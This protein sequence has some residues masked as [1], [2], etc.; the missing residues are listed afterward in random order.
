MDHAVI[1]QMVSLARITKGERVLEI[2]TGTGAVTSEL[3]RVA[4]EVEGYEID[5]KNF[6]ATQEA[7]SDRRL[8]LHLGDAFRATPKFDVLVS[9]LPYSESASFVEWI[10]RMLYD[11]AVVI[12]QD[13]FAMKIMSLPG[14][15]D[16]RAISVIAQSSTHIE[17]LAKV[18]RSAFSPQPRVNSVIVSLKPIRRLSIA[19]TK[20]IKRLFALRR[21]TISAV[22]STNS[23]GPGLNRDRRRVYSLTPE[24]VLD[25]LPMM[26]SEYG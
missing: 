21:R 12:L 6:D 26:R 1:E 4:S 2:G 25:I 17:M 10:S 24:E 8:R 9:S 3:L 16:Y 22:V 11:R 14:H 13:D 5:R 18:P 20:A 15:R 7:I 23:G 19:Q